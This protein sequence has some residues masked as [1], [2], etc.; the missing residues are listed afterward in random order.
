MQPAIFAAL[1]LRPLLDVHEQQQQ[2]LSAVRCDA[3]VALA[4]KAKKKA[5]APSKGGGFGGAP[6]AN[7][8]ANGK[9]APGPPAESAA[10]RLKKSMKLY[11]ELERETRTSDDEDDDDDS[12]SSAELSESTTKYV[13][14]IRVPGSREFHDWTPIALAAL[15]QGGRD[16]KAL[17]P[18]AIGASCR[19]VLEAGCGAVTSLRKADRPSIE[20]AYEPL[21]SFEKMFDGLLG[22]GDKKRDALETL[23]L[24]GDAADEP[25]AVKKAHR[26]LMMTLHPDRFVGDDDGAAEAADRM[27][28]VQAAYELLGGG[29]GSAGDSWYS[30]VGGKARVDF[31]GAVEK[32]ALGALGQE[33][34]GQTMDVA[35]GGWRVGVYPMQTSVVQEFVMRNTNRPVGG[36]DDS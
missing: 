13:V 33:R 12:S 36:G 28:K 10:D 21:D 11:T 32:S 2:H 19:E 27:L 1:L 9:K 14:T 23:G 35:S 34:L 30:S 17:M 15:K 22:S 31:S 24:E 25:G 16:P 8:K 18:D 6:K 7:G 3:P 26:K 4:A 29:Q 5:K 20:F